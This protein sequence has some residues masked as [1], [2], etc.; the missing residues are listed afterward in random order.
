MLAALSETRRVGVSLL[1]LWPPP[2]EG[3]LRAS[4]VLTVSDTVPRVP[5]LRTRTRKLDLGQVRHWFC[6]TARKWLHAS[7]SSVVS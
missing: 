2:S 5:V 6:V 1:F 7:G 4:G 3:S